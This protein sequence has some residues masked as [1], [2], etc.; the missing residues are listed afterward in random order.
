MPSPG[1]VS[2]STIYTFVLLLILFSKA[3]IGYVSRGRT[4][5]T[6]LYVLAQLSHVPV[7]VAVKALR[8]NA[9]PAKGFAIMK[10]VMPD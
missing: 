4:A 3:A 5:P 10:F 6:S 2:T 7:L 8:N 1:L 9:V